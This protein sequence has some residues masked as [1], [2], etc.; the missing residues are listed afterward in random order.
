M[1]DV[2]RLLTTFALGAALML[3]VGNCRSLAE[4]GGA[5]PSPLAGEGGPRVS[6]G[7]KSDCLSGQAFFGFHGV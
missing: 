2:K 1:H 7:R 6:G 5:H 4:N 3:I